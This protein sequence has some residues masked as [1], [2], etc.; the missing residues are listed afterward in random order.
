MSKTTALSNAFITVW[1]HSDQKIVHHQIHKYICGS[2]L[3]EANNVGTELLRQHGACKWLSDDRNAGPL[4]PEDLQWAHD[5]FTPSAVKAGWKYWALVLPEKAVAQMNMKRFQAEF[6]QAGVTVQTFSDPE[7][8]M[9]WLE[10][11]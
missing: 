6:A 1:Y 7:A 11:L 8:G 4:P 2:P 10:S 5:V 9:T 3:R